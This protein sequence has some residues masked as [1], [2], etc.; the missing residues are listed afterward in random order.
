MYPV[1][2]TYTNE[3]TLSR[4]VREVGEGRGEGFE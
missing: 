4:E 1:F 3:V 2:P